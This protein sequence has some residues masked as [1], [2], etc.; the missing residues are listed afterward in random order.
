MTEH[1]LPDDPHARVIDDYLVR[2][3]RHSLAHDVAARSAA[4]VG[5]ARLL[6]F[7]A[8]ASAIAFVARRPVSS[9][10]GW[11]IGLIGGGVFLVLVRRHRQLTTVAHL[12]NAL[13]RVCE[14]GINR[15]R[16]NWTALPSV[17]RLT[18]A[19][20]HPFAADL[21]LAGET[22]LTQ[23][24][25]PVSAG[26]G[27]E[28]LSEWLLA[29]SPPPIDVLHGRQEVIRELQPLADWRERLGVYAGGVS[30]GSSLEHFL[31]WAEDMPWLRAAPGTRNAARLLGVLT[32]LAVLATLGRAI[33]A[34]IA[35]VLLLASL[36]LTGRARRRLNATLDQASSR[37]LGGRA[38]A[39][40]LNHA[41]GVTFQSDRLRALQDRM[42]GS[43]AGPAF[44]R[45]A[46]IAT[47][48]DLRFSPMAHF[49]VHTLTLW[50]FHVVDA[51]DR[52]QLEHG[53]VMRARLRALGELESHAA[54]ATLAHDNP[55]WGFPVFHGDDTRTIETT[56]LAHPLL[57][58]ATRVANDVT[59][60]PPRTFLLVTGSNMAGKTTLLRSVAL[61]VVLAQTGAPVC[62]DDFR[63]PRVRLRTSIHVQDALE[64]GL[65]LFMV[66]LL[67]LKAIVDA[68]RE[69]DAIT[70]L[71][72]AD[73][74]LRGTNV[75]ERRPAVGAVLRHLL[76]AGAIG[77]IATHDLELATDPEL[78]AH[79][80]PVHLIER[81]RDTDA[82]PVMWFDYRLRPGIS[83]SRN[84]LKLLEMVGLGVDDR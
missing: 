55:T 34:W 54:L 60:G 52:W 64:E 24:L 19:R 62:A 20:T 35:V 44:E 11:A 18:F 72:I 41:T 32:P 9:A 3:E 14:T 61:N 25:G 71:Y 83:T 51:L 37:G 2:A 69:S 40:M 33:P 58:A 47:C 68:A 65:S 80:R 59:I 81:F 21:H 13:R 12:H 84:A 74:M 4:R 79:A 16:R 77:A 82:G 8:T 70:L 45:L 75:Q 22:S 29:E 31:T 36:S 39:R 38:Y 5:W 78:A 63:L 10:I 1:S 26:P 7:V 67:R 30:G 49:I 17:M 57:S 28:V 43:A 23:L 53:R 42:G 27:Q 50:D 6:I 73:E 15:I 46:Q 76:Q 66:E 56:G 48:A